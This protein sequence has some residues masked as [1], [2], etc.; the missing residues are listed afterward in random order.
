MATASTSTR[1]AASPPALIALIVGGGLAVSAPQYTSRAYVDLVGQGVG[2]NDTVVKVTRGDRHYYY[3]DPQRAAD[4][5]AAIDLLD[6]RSMPGET[7]VVGTGD[8]RFTPYSDAIVYWM[9]PELKP[10]TFFIEM[11]PGLANLAGNGLAED[12]AEADWVLQTRFWDEW[13]EPNDSANP[14]DPLPN[15]VLAEHFCVV[16]EWPTVILSERCR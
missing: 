15:Q 12:I 7:L 13:D 16:G 9:F 5:Q 4:L 8:L 11:D 1:P 2:I 6:E 14:G 10:G 3:G